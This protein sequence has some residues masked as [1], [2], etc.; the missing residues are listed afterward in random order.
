MFRADVPLVRQIHRFLGIGL[1][2]PC[3]TVQFLPDP[4]SISSY[5]LDMEIFVASNPTTIHRSRLKPSSRFCVFQSCPCSTRSSEAA[6]K[7]EVRFGE[8]P[9]I[10]YNTDIK[11]ICLH[12][13]GNLSESWQGPRYLLQGE[14]IGLHA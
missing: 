11:E 7:E 6:E 2:Y 12:L 14:L 1:L 9:P 4:N 8:F 13:L 3:P 5:E 10:V